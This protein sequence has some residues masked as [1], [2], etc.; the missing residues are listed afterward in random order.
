[1]RKSLV[2]SVL[3][4]ASPNS[5]LI[6]HLTTPCDIKN[7]VILIQFGPRYYIIIYIRLHVIYTMQDFEV[8]CL[9]VI[10]YFILLHYALYIG[11]IAETQKMTTYLSFVIMLD[12]E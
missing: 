12:L 9:M 10:T 7:G 6:K 3:I 2:N 11:D 5:V 4:D 1:M 8:F